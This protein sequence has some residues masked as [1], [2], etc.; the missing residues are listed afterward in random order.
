[1]FKGILSFRKIMPNGLV[2]NF[3]AIKR[4]HIRLF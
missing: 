4:V 2:N 3:I 1:M